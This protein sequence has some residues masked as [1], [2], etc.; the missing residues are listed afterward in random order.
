ME[1]REYLF[2]LRTVSLLFV[3][4]FFTFFFFLSF[5][6]FSFL[7]LIIPVFYFGLSF[8]LLFALISSFIYLFI[9]ALS[10][11]PF[12]TSITTF[13]NLS[14]LLSLILSF[15][16]RSFHCFILSLLFPFTLFHQFF[17]CSFI[18]SLPHQ[19]FISFIS[20]FL[21][22][23]SILFLSFFHSLS[24]VLSFCCFYQ[25]SFLFHLYFLVLPVVCVSD[26]GQQALVCDACSFLVQYL[27]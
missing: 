17:A 9:F 3:L 25:L 10:S 26:Y 7:V 4:S 24:S 2:T 23:F 19:F 13:F 18:L 16:F 1:N 27:H 6:T 8:H 15:F 20:S 21:F 22:L 11:F 5:P 12:P 14:G